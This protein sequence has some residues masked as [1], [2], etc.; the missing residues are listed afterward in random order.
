M[1]RL[2]AT[3]AAAALLGG[4]ASTA[5]AHGPAHSH[6]RYVVDRAY[7]HHVRHVRRDARRAHRRAHR[8]AHRHARRHHIRDR[9]VRRYHRVRHHGYRHPCRIGHRHYH[10]AF[11]YYGDLEA[12]ALGAVAYAIV[13]E[14]FD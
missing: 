7:D 10:G 12:V 5:E 13:R 11:A 1:N 3:L 2:L 6:G 8:H 4:L 14:V 9:H